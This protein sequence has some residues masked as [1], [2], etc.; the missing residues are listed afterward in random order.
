MRRRVLG[1]LSAASAAVLVGVGAVWASAVDPPDDSALLVGFFRTSEPVALT[2][3]TVVDG[4]YL[5]EYGAAVQF[6]SRLPGAVLECGLVDA[7]GRIGYLDGRVFAVPA[8]TGWVRI[9]DSTTYDVPEITLGIRCTPT[10][11]GPAGIGYRDMTLT[12]EPIG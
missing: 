1:G 4:A 2:N 11:A 8:N 5:V 7:S 10:V 12:A 6:H 3:L 9:G